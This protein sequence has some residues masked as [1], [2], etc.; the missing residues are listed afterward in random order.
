MRNG[1]A[2]E[3]REIPKENG[4][5]MRMCFI[6]GTFFNFSKGNQASSQIF[7]GA[8]P[9]SNSVSQNGSNSVPGKNSP[10]PAPTQHLSCSFP[11]KYENGISDIFEKQKEPSFKQILRRTGDFCKMMVFQNFPRTVLLGKRLRSRVRRTP[12]YVK[13][14][15]TPLEAGQPLA[16]K[17]SGAIELVELQDEVC[18]WISSG[19][20]PAS[21]ICVFSFNHGC[22]GYLFKTKTKTNGH[23]GYSEDLSLP[24]LVSYLVY[25]QTCF[26]KRRRNGLGGATPYGSEGLLPRLHDIW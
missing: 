11:T 10:S 13:A 15:Q 6:E 24:D 12:S 26:N 9:H 23:P 3:L 2:E 21:H 5:K 18:L 25:P 14:F 8:Y 17:V 19:Q 20:S 4:L 7:C 16:L 22:P 1:R